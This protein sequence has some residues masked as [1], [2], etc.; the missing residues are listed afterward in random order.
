MYVKLAECQTI[1]QLHIVNCYIPN[2]YFH[3]Y[4]KKLEDEL[5]NIDT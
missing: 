3:I 2:N 1:L 4:W 5:R